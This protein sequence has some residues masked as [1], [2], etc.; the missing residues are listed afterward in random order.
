MAKDPTTTTEAVL[1]RDANGTSEMSSSSYSRLL[2]DEEHQQ[3][4]GMDS[5]VS[6]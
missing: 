2:V 5:K 4:L 1:R 3:A 6:S